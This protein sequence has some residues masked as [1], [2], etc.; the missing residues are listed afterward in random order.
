MVVVRDVSCV[1]CKRFSS[2]DVVAASPTRSGSAR[3]TKTEA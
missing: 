2:F 1:V 3:E